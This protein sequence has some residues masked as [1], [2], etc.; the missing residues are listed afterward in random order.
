MPKGFSKTASYVCNIKLLYPKPSNEAA[1]LEALRQYRILDS[2]NEQ[3][4]DDVVTLA[5]HLCDTPMATI[6]LLDE[7]RQWFKAKVGL[8]ID[9]TPREHAFCTHAIMHSEV[10]IV[11]DATADDRF[12]DNPLVTGDP[13]VRFYAG[14]PLA[15]P[16]AYNVGTICVLDSRTR[17]LNNEQRDS[18]EV[19]GRVVVTMLEQR[20][21]TQTLAEAL[22]NVRMLSGLLPICAH[23]KAVRD[24]EGFWRRVED[25]VTTNT[26]AEFT[27]S[28]CP[29]CMRQHYPQYMEGYPD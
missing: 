29:K 21:L 28:I 8:P 16:D 23:C 11:E 13:H 14:A 27:H 20:K 18:L 5:A 22:E 12:R 10:M 6:S 24:D 25:Y 2:G 19:L 3:L 1:R 4:Y 17:V 15:T 9:G 7:D 26:G